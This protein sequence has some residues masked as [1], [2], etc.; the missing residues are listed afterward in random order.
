VLSAVGNRAAHH[1]GREA[2]PVTP[3]PIPVTTEWNADING[4]GN[5]FAPPLLT[6]D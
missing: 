4:E 1:S 3:D 5:R 6:K 2:K